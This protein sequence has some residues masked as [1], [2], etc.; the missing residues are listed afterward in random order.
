MVKT[1][2]VSKLILDKAGVVAQYQAAATSGTAHERALWGSEASMRGRFTLALDTLQDYPIQRWLDI[3]CGEA[4]FFAE[5]ELRGRRCDRLIGV[6]L[7]ATMIDRARRKT[8]ASPS[9]FHVADLEALPETIDEIDLVTLIGVLQQSGMPLGK[10]VAAAA[11]PLKPGGI[12]LLTTKHIGWE[13]FTSGALTP[14]PEHAW[15]AADEVSQALVNAGLDVTVQVGI[16]PVERRF[17]PLEQSH[18]MLVVA[19][20]RW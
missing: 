8:F 18:T 2:T 3:G 9:E 13:R 19:R 7:T 6:D 11:N 16:L 14:E 10:A 20:K 4:D 5:A 15:F 12:L 17:V 1:T